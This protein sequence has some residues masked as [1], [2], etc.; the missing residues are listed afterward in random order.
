MY[1]IRRNNQLLWLLSACLILLLTACSTTPPTTKGTPTPGRHPTT[2]AHRMIT[3]TIASTTITMPSTQTDCPPTGTARPQVTAP[4]ALGNHQNIIYTLN[5]GT[6]DT[7]TSGALIR[8]DTQTRQKTV[9]ITVSHAHIYEA[10]VSADGQWVLFVTTTGSISRQSRLQLLRVDGQGLQTLA[11]VPGYSLQ[12]MQWS[13]DQHYLVYY[14]NVNDQGIVYLLD[15]LT[16]TLQTE[17]T[18]PPQVGLLLRTWFDATHIYVSDRAIDTLYTHLY[19][20]DIKKGAMQ[21]LS[22][23]STVLFQQYS[24]FDSSDDSSSLFTTD[25]NCRDDTC[26]GPSHIVIQPVTGGPQHTIYRSQD[27]D[28]IELR[29]ID[30]NSMLF[31]IGNSPWTPDTSHNGLWSMRINGT[32]LT[33]LVTTTTQQ[34][35]YMN[36][37]SQQP[38]SNIS[39]DSS[40]YVIQVNEFQNSIEK[41]S[42][43]VGSLPGG[44]AKVFA[45]IADGS[46]LGVVGWTVM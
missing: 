32:N 20:L 37:G 44:R 35:S 17:L 31:I 28:V 25:G 4:L 18:T 46:Q 33:H 41:H 29:A 38:W 6:Y 9:L 23:L 19:L 5:R 30:R 24:D 22:D 13:T 14:N 16:G 15:M 26:N 45:S 11:C 39:R 1:A 3:P 8:Y 7:P 36:Y 10:Q 21:H 12:Q 40:M 27:Y 34:Y 2:P 43:R 42:L